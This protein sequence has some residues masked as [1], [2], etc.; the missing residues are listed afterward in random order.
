MNF[1]TNFAIEEILFDLQL[2]AG[3]VVPSNAAENMMTSASPEVDPEFGK[4][5][6]EVSLFGDKKPSRREIVSIC[7]A[8][9]GMLALFLI[10]V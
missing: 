2:F 5:N 10:P 1:K 9:I 4:I 8:F 7:L 6:D 3:T